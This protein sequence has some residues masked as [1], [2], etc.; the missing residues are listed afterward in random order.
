MR[1]TDRHRPAAHLIVALIVAAI[2]VGCQELPRPTSEASDVVTFEAPSRAHGIAWVSQDRLVIGSRETPTDPSR[3]TAVDLAT[4]ESKVLPVP[5]GLTCER[6]FLQNPVRQ[7]DDTILLTATCIAP[8]DSSRPDHTAVVSQGLESAHDETLAFTEDI[9][10]LAG[11]L[12][13]D[14]ARSRFLLDFGQLCGV[15]VEA[16]AAG[17]V[18]LDLEVQGDA[19]SFSLSDVGP[20]PDC[21]QR[22]WSGWPSWSVNDE[23]A[24]F[25]STDAIG[26][27]GQARGSAPAGLYLTTPA[28]EA[29]ALLVDGVVVPRGLTWSPDGSRLAFGGEIDG[30]KAT[31][32]VDPA[33]GELREVFDERLT[34]LAW[35]PDGAQLAGLTARG[36]DTSDSQIVIIDAK[37]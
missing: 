8:L 28:F 20:G 1:C 6:S 26:L 3:L 16:T 36:A 34:W 31:W 27:D 23:I 21:R 12:A 15:I 14:P 24:F 19:G 2:A 17:A 29:S 30:H 25:A 37:D 4:R 22:G 10:G 35:S 32:V 11:A 33:S 18:P 5:S 13:V 9:S 7:S